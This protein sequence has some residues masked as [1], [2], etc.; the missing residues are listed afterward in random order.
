MITG[1]MGTAGSGKRW[2]VGDIDPAKITPDRKVFGVDPKDPK[3]A[4]ERARLLEE[5]FKRMAAGNMRVP[6]ESLR[7]LKVSGAIEGQPLQTFE[8]QQRI[9]NRAHSGAN[10]LLLGDA[11][12]NGH[13]SVG[14]GMHVGAVSHGERFKQ[15]L[16][17]VDGGTPMARASVTYSMNVLSDTRAWG[18]DGLYYFYNNLTREQAEQIYNEAANLYQEGKVATPE[19]ALE[20]IVPVTERK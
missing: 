5:E 6:V 13:W 17:A 3:F 4:A 16:T 8:L 12:G 1:S 9:S 15:F 20:L 11:V 18:E 14:G 10:V 7:D 2:V 19:R